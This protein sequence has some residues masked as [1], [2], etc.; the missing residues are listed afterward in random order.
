MKAQLNTLRA[1]IYRGIP[2]P[3]DYLSKMRGATVLPPRCSGHI[4][5]ISGPKYSAPCLNITASHGT[6]RP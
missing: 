2:V 6:L 4:R 3:A 5:E 1:V